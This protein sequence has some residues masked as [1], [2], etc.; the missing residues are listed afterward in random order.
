[1]VWFICQY[2]HVCRRNHRSFKCKFKHLIRW[3][4]HGSPQCG[5]GQQF[6]N[7]RWCTWCLTWVYV[8]VYVCVCVCVC[9]HASVCVCVCVR[10]LWDWQKGPKYQNSIHGF[11]IYG[12]YIAMF[13]KTIACI[14]MQMSVFISSVLICTAYHSNE[15]YK[16]VKPKSIKYN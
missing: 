14:A 7:F 5:W 3:M 10:T 11:L 6:L 2:K 15:V 16:T 1:M 13:H 8:C 12:P 4:W 9:V